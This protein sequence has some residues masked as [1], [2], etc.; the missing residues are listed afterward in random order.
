M[1][2][3]VDRELARRRRRRL[4][5]PAVLVVLALVGFSIY[6]QI[7]KINE[8]VSYANDEE[9]FKYGSIGSDNQGIPYWIWKTMPEVC[10]LA[11]GYAALGAVQEPG[12]DTP[13]GFSKRRVGP[14]TQVA[15]NCGICHTA[16]VRSAPDAEPQIYLAA[17]AH[18]LDLGGYFKFLFSC[19]RHPDFTTEKFLDAIGRHTD[20]G[21]VD[22]LVYR[23][24]VPRVRDALIDGGAKFN[25]ITEGRPDWGPGRVDTFNPY[26][27]LLFKAD[28][29]KDRSIG[30]AD[31]LSVWNQ[32]PREGV[33]LHWDGNNDSVDERNLSAAIGAGAT[34][35]TLD[36][37]RIDRIKRWITTQPPPAYPY[38]IDLALAAQGKPI[39]GH[40]CAACHDFGGAHF[41]SVTRLEGLRTDPERN[42]AFDK[43]MAAQMNTIGEG[44]PWQF[45]RFRTTDG[46]ANHPLDGIWL[47][48][49]YLHN[50]AV[51]TLRDLLNTP[52][53]RPPVFYRGNDVYDP[54]NVG[55]VSDVERYGD[56]AFFRFD[57]RE[58]G[59][60]NGG[61]IYGT[62]LS[63]PE[64]AA[65]LEYLKTL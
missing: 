27:V 50:G 1:L 31:F 40:Y 42:K 7:G 22:R 36:H 46:Y 17:A 56:K 20:L 13:I 15:P 65:L 25:S 38:P 61:H 57:T 32:A 29:S 33:W 12:K 37:A 44:Y 55:F 53:R 34:P 45:R 16:T 19:G 48:A 60:G 62:E 14:V 64:K 35:D 23:I 39:Y 9:H 63:E 43:K 21:M 47:R 41:G 3:V 2:T 10:G 24:A 58:R 59:N 51:P 49:P 28:M 30:T 4:A 11:G 5:I 8:P 18:Q 26:K 6:Q 54:Y 52:D